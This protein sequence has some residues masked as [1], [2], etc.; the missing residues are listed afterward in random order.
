M[1][2]V[3]LTDIHGD[4]DAVNRMATILQLADLVVL[5]GDLTLFGRRHAAAEILGAVAKHCP[6]VLAVHG[7]CDYPEVDDYLAEKGV[8][9]HGR[10]Q[11]I[12][13]ATFFGVGG[14]LPCLGHTPNELDE[15][16][17][18]RF[19]AQGADGIDAGLPSVLVSHQ[20]PIDTKLDLANGGAHVGSSSVRAC[21]EAV[22]PLVCFTGHIH[23]ARGIDS[24]GRTQLVNPGPAGDGHYAYAVLD[25][26]LE[27]LEIR[28]FV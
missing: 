13:G 28:S 16:E 22:Q 12:H 17:L 8:S 2:V 14:S 20:P 5:A 18:K 10:S 15:S 11:I 21:V 26:A 27:E 7:N 25:G 19:L 3:G 23:E 24:L 1:I 9:L 6:F 4:V